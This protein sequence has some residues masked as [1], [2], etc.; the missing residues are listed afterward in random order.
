M[1]CLLKTHGY[2]YLSWPARTDVVFSSLVWFLKG[3]ITVPVFKF[4][5][6]TGRN[7]YSSCFQVW[8]GYWKEYLQFLFSS[9]VWLLE[10][11]ITDPVFKF[12]LVTGR[13]TYS[14]CSQ[15]WFG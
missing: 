10:G 15:V 6:V 2:D 4:G 14:S 12:G 1:L 11:T 8:F 5:L 9:L 7:T 3:I 13:N